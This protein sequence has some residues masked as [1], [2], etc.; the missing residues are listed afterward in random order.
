MGLQRKIRT[1]SPLVFMTVVCA[2]IL[3][4]YAW[5]AWNARNTAIQV[6]R[7]ETANLAQ[8]LA[9]HAQNLF[10]SADNGLL[11]LVE[12][13][14]TEGSAP[15]AV[16]RLDRFLSARLAARSGV[17]AI[18]VFDKAGRLA[19]SARTA[20]GSQLTDAGL[21]DIHRADPSRDLRFGPLVH[22]AVTGVW[23]KI[24]SRRFDDD[25]GGFAG[26]VTTQIDL[27]AVRDYYRLFDVGSQGA[28]GLLTDGGDILAR[29]P[30]SEKPGRN[31]A[32]DPY[33]QTYL[34]NGPVISLQVISSVDSITRQISVH[35]TENY[36][37]AV[38]VGR[39]QAEILQQWWKDTL[40]EL[41]AVLVVLAGVCL[42]GLRL[43]WHARQA[44]RAEI[45]LQHSESQYRLLA[46]NSTDVVI[47]LSADLQRLF[48]SPSSIELLGY[49][50]EQMLQSSGKRDVHPDDWNR[51]SG[52]LKGLQEDGGTV[53]FTYR[54]RHQS[55]E[56]IWLDGNSRWVEG[57]RAFIMTLRNVSARVAAEQA[58]H[59]ANNRLQRLVM[60]DG[61][62]GIANRRCFDQ[63]L[64]REFRR[65]LRTGLPLALL[66][67]DADRFKVFN[68][69]YGHQAGDDCLCAIAA[70]LGPLMRRPADLVARYGGEEFVVMLPETDQAGAM[71]L[72]E[73]IRSEIR[74]LAIPHS[75][76]GSAIVTVSIGVA[77]AVPGQQAA[78][79]AALLAEADQALYVAKAEGRDRVQAA[80]WGRAALLEAPSP[81]IPPL[82]TQ[83]TP[84]P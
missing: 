56:F 42:L 43:V 69:T 27:G 45:T 8:S 67:I 39:A 75:G 79:S 13:L 14:E 29:F 15:A 70:T 11:F 47:K 35:R 26:I 80:K 55:G 31:I 36:P 40:R 28:I 18:A 52:L 33:F 6:A 77:S 3:G 51:V 44:R 17:H 41:V 10:K 34:R 12:R 5:G 64:D 71:E 16:R 76:T 7:N 73:H 24:L 66:M 83:S 1:P 78:D 2:L 61:L 23:S 50:P 37:V 30:G 4:G 20:G 21:L 46:D 62:T 81:E 32:G 65:G 68:D 74:R 72:A 9:E 48:V 82:E 53:S 84:S 63:L 58:L 57:E 54:F 38:F 49:T 19:A 25:H 22:D 60:L 59:E